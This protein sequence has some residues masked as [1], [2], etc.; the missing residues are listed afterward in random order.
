MFTV[1]API[2]R[3]HQRL[4][5]PRLRHRVHPFFL[6]G[7]GAFAGL[8]AFNLRVP[9]GPYIQPAVLDGWLAIALLAGATRLVRN[10][11]EAWLLMSCWY[12]GAASSVPGI[13]TQFFGHS[14]LES[15]AGFGVWWAFAT[16]LALPALISPRKYPGMGVVI[17]ALCA[18]IPPLGLIGIG[19]PLVLAGALFPGFGWFGM[20]LLAL[21][22]GLSAYTASRKVPHWRL[23]LTTSFALLMVGLATIAIPAPQAPTMTWADE[24]YLGNRAFHDVTLRYAQMAQVRHFTDQALRQGAKVIVLPEATD[25]TWGKGEAWFWQRTADLARHQHATVLLG[26]YTSSIAAPTRNDALLD[27]GT[28]KRYAADV[29]VPFGMWAPWRGEDFPLHLDHATERSLI[30]TPF[31]PAAHLICYE[32]LLP[33]PLEEQE[34]AGRPKLLVSAAD[35]WFATGMLGRAQ[36]RSVELQARLWGLPLLRAVNHPDPFPLAQETVPNGTVSHTRN[37]SYLASR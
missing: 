7:V 5:A 18:A 20:P 15:A 12:L 8:L 29:T 30:P 1:P 37:V 36:T 10:R 9:I 3:F 16:L 4:T 24:T 34:L 6:A 14:A 27:L 26:I 32:E 33:W 21:I 35:Q 22:L 17:A 31:G 28:G 13:W 11:G 25:P 19:N 2:A 23:A